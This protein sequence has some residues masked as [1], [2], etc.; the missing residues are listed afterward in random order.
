M[1]LQFAIFGMERVSSWNNETQKSGQ[2]YLFRKYPKH[3]DSEEQA[4]AE[5]RL[6]LSGNSPYP[7]FRFSNYTI[8]PVIPS[9]L[10]SSVAPD[11]KVNAKKDSSFP[12][13]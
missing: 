10:N 13:Y 7:H 8:M 1:K 12:I 2:P 4:Y 6:I 3:F 11:E 5:L 9:S